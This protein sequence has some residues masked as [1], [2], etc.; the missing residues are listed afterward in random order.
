MDLPKLYELFVRER[1]YLKNVS[2]NTLEWYKYSFRAFQRN[3]TAIPDGKDLKPA[4]RA[5]IVALAGAG[6]QPSSINDYIRAMNAFLRWALDEGHLTG[7]IRLDYLKEE[8]KVIPTLSP[9]QVRHILHWKPSTFCGKRLHALCCLILDTG[10]RIE[11]CLSVVRAG[12]DFE[13]LLICV[14][15]K[16]RKQRRVPMSFEL[17]KVLWRFAPLHSGLTLF[18]TVKGD[19][20]DQR[21]V[22]REFKRL[23]KSLRIEGVRFSPHTLRHTFA[24]GYLRHGGNVFYLQRILG[25]SSLEMTNRYVRSLGVEDL[26]AVHERLSLLTAHR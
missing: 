6:L 26:K 20:L 22:L 23:G 11:E 19:K 4:P 2:P 24:V 8:E 17:R 13:N 3:L 25:H 15:G 18:A 12:V 9:E 1:Q 10:L 21:N 16:G 5:A 14:T 7:A